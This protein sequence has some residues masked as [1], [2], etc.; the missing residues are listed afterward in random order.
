[1][2]P[3]I[4]TN[5]DRHTIKMMKK[6]IDLLITQKADESEINKK[7]GHNQLEEQKMAVK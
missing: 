1:M 5:L 7:I 4:H 2:F 6:F 3:E